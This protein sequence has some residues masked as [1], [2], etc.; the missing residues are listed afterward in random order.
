MRAV[1]GGQVAAPQRGAGGHDTWLEHYHDDVLAPIDAACAAGGPDRFA[2]FSELDI[3]LWALLL[4]KDYSAYPNIHAL[5]P[6]R[7]P[8]DAAGALERDVGRA[9]R[10]PE[11]GVLPSAPGSLRRG[12]RAPAGGLARARLRLRLGPA[13][14]LPR[15]RRA[16][17]RL[18]GCDP[19]ES[20]LAVCRDSG[21]PATLARSELVP[22]RL[23]FDERFDLAFAFSVFTHL[24]EP[25]H[26]RCLAAL[27]AGLRPGAILVV[28]IRPPDYMP[29]GARAR[30][31]SLR[32]RPARR[33]PVPPAVRGR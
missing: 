11:R 3:D 7:A 33:R 4:T 10:E 14:A 32:L 27:H 12:G 2:L 25:A 29:V 1:R 31:P 13:D 30:W 20:I 26:E 23:P 5:L 22:E 16:A 19:V 24:S 21:V 28:T 18:Y 9:A 15:P 6:T 17:S 8:P